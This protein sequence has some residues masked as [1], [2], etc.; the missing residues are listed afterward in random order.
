M[1]RNFKAQLPKVISKANKEISTLIENDIAKESVLLKDLVDQVIKANLDVKKK[2]NQRILDTKKRL[3]DLDKQIDDLTVSI[4]LLDR[5]TIIEQLNEMIDAKNKIFIARQEIRF[6]DNEKLPYNLETLNK[7]YHTLTSPV[8]KVREFDQ[9]YRTTLFQHNDL[10]KE[11]QLL[12]TNTISSMLKDLYKQKFDNL[13]KSLLGL[14]TIKE[15]IESYELVYL[16]Q[17]SSAMHLE[18]ELLDQSK[19]KFYNVDSDEILNKQIT[20]EHNTNK[21]NLK[22]K[23]I[24]IT[25]TYNQKQKE[26]I[27]QYKEYETSVLEKFNSKN[28]QALE[29]QQAATVKIDNEL[30]EIR[31][32]IMQAEKRNDF[33]SVTVL[34][35]KFDKVEKQRNSKTNKQLNK[36]SSTLTDS[37]KQKTNQQ[38]RDLELNYIKDKHNLN[39]EVAYEEIRF[40]EAKILHKIKTDYD[41]LQSDFDIN[42]KRVTNIKEILMLKSKLLSEIHKVR[43][44]LRYLELDIMKENDILELTIYDTFKLLLSELKDI[45]INRTDLIKQQIET[46]ELIKLEQ[47]FKLNKAIEDIKLNQ[48]THSIDKQILIKR[49]GTLIDIQKEIE[50]LN[51]ELIYQES[52]IAIAKKE[53]ELQLIKVQSLYENERSLA[54]EQKD[55]INLGIKVNETF[56]KTTLKNQLLFAEQQIQ[57]AASEYD[58]RVESINLTYDQEVTY[59][60]K[61]I[62]YYKQK[63]EYEKTKLEKELEDKLEDLNYKLLLFTES[64]DNKEI[65]HKIEDLEKYYDKEIS[66]ILEQEQQDKEIIRYEKVISDAKARQTS[67]IIEAETL[68]NNTVESFRSLYDATKQKYDDVLEENTE[69]KG[70]IPLLTNKSNESSTSRLAQATKEA[71][72]LFEER[73]KDSYIIIE[74]TKQKIKDLNDTDDTEAFIKEQR[75]LKIDKLEQHKQKTETIIQKRQEDILPYQEKLTLDESNR[76]KEKL[77]E[78]LFV[79]MNIMTPTIIE[80]TYTK[81][82]KDSKDI[83]YQAILQDQEYVKEKQKDIDSLHQK[84]INELKQAITPYK[85]YMRFA[86]KGV[87]ASKKELKSDSEKRLRKLTNEALKELKEK[88]YI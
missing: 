66:D 16:E 12:L 52:L 24:D 86:S 76:N 73:T 68:R 83:A 55:R 70:I 3:K 51:S 35:K 30:K 49:N 15:S 63:Y 80:E 18:Y 19:S 61:K 59:A 21:N 62:D 13:N 34:L 5:E 56:V 53:H 33:K 8:E 22:Q 54:E 45:E 42:K 72:A 39:Y 28:K 58:I 4:E 87:N 25:E 26:I 47:E 79:N 41:G 74:E 27:S 6:F 81:R 2:N 29:K 77:S 14:D 84:T 23:E 67:A 40:Q 82:K 88:T 46:H 36:E 64:K 71:D 65:K 57:V 78:S 48:E 10:L 9:L 31:L 37:R 85:K 69:Q 32:D 43:L 38:L 17:L 60:Q 1:A 11:K 44:E 75:K 20:E 50:N 7:I